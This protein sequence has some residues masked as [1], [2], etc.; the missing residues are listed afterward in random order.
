LNTLAHV[1]RTFSQPI[2][3]VIGGTHLVNADEA[4]LQ[5]VVEVLRDTYGTLRYYLN[6]CTGEQAFLALANAFGD[7]V[8]LCPAGTIL[9]F[10]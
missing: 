1:Q 10:E 7:Q 4:H 8:N 2:H 6:H 9:E 3:T 5:Y